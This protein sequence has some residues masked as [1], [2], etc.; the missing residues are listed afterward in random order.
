[1]SEEQVRGIPEDLREQYE[2]HKKWLAI[3]WHERPKTQPGI[4]AILR[5]NSVNDIERI[6]RSEQ[7]LA[8][9]EARNKELERMLGTVLPKSSVTTINTHVH[10]WIERIDE[11]TGKGYSSCDGCAAL[12]GAS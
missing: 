9:L 12:K 1:M 6:A 8:A 4:E 2:L 7:A 3:P 11:E 5:E 10:S